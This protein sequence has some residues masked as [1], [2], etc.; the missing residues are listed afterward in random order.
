MSLG[1][2]LEV[3]ASQSVVTGQLRDTLDHLVAIGYD[4]RD[5]ADFLLTIETLILWP[6]SHVISAFY[7]EYL[8]RYLSYKPQPAQHYAY[9]VAAGYS[10]VAH[11]ALLVLLSEPTSPDESFAQLRQVEASF[12]WPLWEP[13][14]GL[15]YDH[16]FLL[17]S[18]FPLLLTLLCFVYGRGEYGTYFSRKLRAIAAR[19]APPNPVTTHCLVWLLLAS[20]LSGDIASYDFAREALNSAGGVTQT[21]VLSP[22]AGVNEEGDERVVSG[23]DRVSIPPFNDWADWLGTMVASSRPRKPLL[24]IILDAFLV[25]HDP[26]SAR[27]A[28]ANLCLH[29]SVQFG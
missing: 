18:E 24:P 7:K 9:T 4:Q 17:L 6:R 19:I 26:E 27:S 15:S 8:P 14:F 2:V 13:Y 11:L 20:R 25:M 16:D 29:K 3:I 28:F 10:D 22:S 21:V 23:T 5:D 12:T 1:A